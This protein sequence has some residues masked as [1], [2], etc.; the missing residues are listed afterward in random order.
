VS[1][2]DEAGPKRYRFGP[3]EIDLQQRLLLRTG[4]SVPITPKAFDTLAVLVARPGRVLEK[5]ELLKLVW[6][7]TFV[8]ENNLTQNI[9]AL[10]KVLGE[11]EYIATVPR[12]GYRFT[13]DVEEVAAPGA[14]K[15]EAPRIPRSVRG[16]RSRS[17]WIGGALGIAAV[18]ALAISALRGI[19]DPGPTV[20]EELTNALTHR[21]CVRDGGFFVR[22]T[23]P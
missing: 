23:A 15:A 13:M 16:R 19:R 3:F 18:T 20:T 10:R 2:I 12:R 4:H 9:S 21:D 11:E 17:G 8:E 5:A 1:C 7:D 14:V 22:G 6:R